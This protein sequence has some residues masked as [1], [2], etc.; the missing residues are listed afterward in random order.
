MQIRRFL[1]LAAGLLF[2]A[3]GTASAQ[4]AG[5]TGVTMGFPASIGIVWHASDKVAI[6]PELSVAG[7]SSEGSGS[8]FSGQSDNVNFVTG[9]SVLFHL[10]TYDHLK[11]YFSPRFTYGRSSSDSTTSAVTT[12]TSETTA[13][14]TGG[15][16]SFGAQYELSDKFSVFGELGFGYSRTKVTSSTSTSTN[17]GNTWSSRSGVGVIF[18]F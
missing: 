11:T 4:G 12:S 8:S 3:C 10:R 6:R 15:S 16:G 1:F 9:V 14:T 5:K 17:T 7:S 18:Y 2:L 13:T